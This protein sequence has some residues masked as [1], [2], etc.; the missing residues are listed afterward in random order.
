[1][2]LSADDLESLSVD[3][4]DRRAW[5]LFICRIPETFRDVDPELSFF[6]E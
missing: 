3:D 2:R 6:C 1:M 4:L 5:H